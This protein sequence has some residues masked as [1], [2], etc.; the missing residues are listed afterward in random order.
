M[1]DGD[2]FMVQKKYWGIVWLFHLWETEEGPRQYKNIDAAR[3]HIFF[4]TRIDAKR[5]NKW[6]VIE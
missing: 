3:E 1:T 5:K 6:M 2:L 4:F